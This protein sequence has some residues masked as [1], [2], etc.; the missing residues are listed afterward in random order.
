MKT[1]PSLKCIARFL[2]QT[3]LLQLF[4]VALATSLLPLGA[5]AQHGQLF[6]TKDR[7]G[8]SLVNQVYRDRHG[9]IWICTENGLERYDGY[10][11]Q[12]YTTDDGLSSNNV[13]CVNLHYNGRLYIGTS[14]GLFVLIN[15]RIHS[16]TRSEGD[17]TALFTPY[18]T[19]LCLG[20]D[21]TLY[22]GTSGRGIWKVCGEKRVER[23]F[24]TIDGLMYAHSMAF[25]SR[26]TLWVVT[27]V[28]GAFAIKG[29]KV[30]KYNVKEIVTHADLK[31]D[32][33]DNVYIG[34]INGGI[35]K[36]NAESDEFKLIPT[37][38]GLQVTSLLVRNDSTIYVGTNG[39]GLHQLDTRTGKMKSCGL[40]SND[41]DMNKVKVYSIAV[42][43]MD[44]LWLG[45]LQKGVFLQP[46]HSNNIIHLGR[47]T[48]LRNPIGESCVMAVYKDSNGTL[49]VATDQD[50]LY[51]IDSQGQL[52]RHYKPGTSPTS[53]PGTILTI[54]EDGRGRL[55]VGSY[56][57][58]CGWIDTRTGVYH[59]APFSYGKV[60]SIFD[61]RTDGGDIMWVGTLGNGLKRYNMKTGEIKEYF[62]SESGSVRNN[63]IM[64]M[65]LDKD[66]KYLFVGTSTGISTLDLQTYE[67]HTYP[68]VDSLFDRIPIRAMRYRS[69][70]GLWVGT[71]EGLYNITSDGRTTHYNK[72]NG[73]QGDKVTGI[74][75]DSIGRVW[76]STNHG[77]MCLTAE[78]GK[79]EGFYEND[80]LMDNEYYEG[81]SFTDSNGL[82]YFG[83][84]MGLSFFDPMKMEHT[85]KQQSVILSQLFVGGQ[86]VKAGDKS[87]DYEI[88]SE[89]VIKSRQFDFA[90]QDNTITLRFSTLT[91]TGLKHI[92][93]RYCINGD[94]WITL[95]AGQ[96]ELTLSRMPTGNYHFKVEAI[97]NGVASE[98]REFTITIHAPWYFTTTAKTIYVIIVIGACFLLLRHMRIRNRER[99]SLQE[100]IHAEELNEQKLQSFINLSHEIR[101]PMT[102]ILTPLEQLIKEDTDSHRRSIYEVIHRNAKRIV[103]LVNQIMDIRKIDKGQMTMQMKET[104]FIGFTEE[105]VDLFRTQAAS[106]QIRLM[107]DHEGFDRLPLWIDRQQFD[108]V[109]M[110]L[111]SNAVKYA[112]TGGEIV[113]SIDCHNGN[114]ILTVSDNGEKIP[115]ESLP[116]IFKR[117]YQSPTDN[118]KYKSG[119]G[120]GLD[121]TRSLVLLHHGTIEVRNTDDGVEF[122]VTIPLGRNHLSESEIAITKTPQEPET[123]DDEET[124]GTDTTFG[125][126]TLGNEADGMNPDTG[127]DAEEAKPAASSNSKRATVVI[128][129]DDDEIRNYLT[130]QLSTHYRVLSFADG[131]QAL[132]TI[133]R[134][135]PQLVISDVMMPN[136]DGTTLCS[137]LKTNINTN[138]IP[139]ILITAKTRDEDKLVG[140]EA[141]ADL[142]I[143]KPFNLDILRRNIAN[144]IDS[145]KLM[146]NKFTGKEDQAAQIDNIEIENNDEKLLGR[147]M[148]VINANLSNSELNIDMVCQEVGISRVHLHRKMKELTNQTPHDFIKNLRLKQAARLL[149]QKGQSVTEVM[150]RCGFNS[151]TSF[152]TIFKKMYGLSPRDY[153]RENEEK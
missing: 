133:L 15:D 33:D 111:M 79:F 107:F 144:L 56:T 101:T 37:T 25:D 128:V 49:W 87:D 150:Y 88:C 114:A 21:S 36:T 136:M 34:H 104:D 51:A 9:M 38:A 118:P 146:K 75:F 47:D 117:F 41:I 14:S 80:G 137:R 48:G 40:Y 120:V 113:V 11:F 62:A 28:N 76:V 147:I 66:G 29:D 97:D 10:H 140:L 81:V 57:D 53:V 123:A 119:T 39:N 63:F 121:L 141:G 124:A 27:N 86:L 44:N 142:Y 134:D 152:S 116:H 91:Y 16:V 73:L 126:D 55:W 65:E 43:N 30:K 135:I 58:G 109:L 138:H 50:G 61:L 1:L 77:L 70:D 139:I 20:P 67:W 78:T 31:I 90:H 69:N 98:P 99:L 106:K 143:T 19:T 103:H 110:N 95:P 131:A 125:N 6:T 60:Q 23:A 96:S 4:I 85:H 52:L 64:Q 153:K 108:K 71:S 8:S 93:Y 129:E 59:R 122:V 83:G 115:E 89:A 42:D 149:R 127:S 68:R 94:E 45:L 74:E 7:L 72:S 112:H 12:S 18:I 102:L 17:G 100:H 2:S 151:A 54:T 132:P 22:I 5:A 46:P 3:T 92:S 13:N 24:D 82:M 130:T 35:Y 32:N 148:K 105:V 26:G 84:T 145:R